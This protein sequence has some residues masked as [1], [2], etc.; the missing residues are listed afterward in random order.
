[1]VK[2]LILTT[3][4]VAP[5]LVLPWQ[6]KA[7]RLRMEAAP[8]AS[9]EDR[10]TQSST[11][12]EKDVEFHR[13]LAAILEAESL[14][15]FS[16][17]TLLSQQPNLNFRFSRSGATP[18]TASVQRWSPTVLKTLLDAGADPDFPDLEGLTPLAHI[19]LRECDETDEANT[20]ALLERSARAGGHID[21][22]RVY[23]ENPY[24]LPFEVWRDGT[25]RKVS[26]VESAF[27][28]NRRGACAE[29]LIRYGAAIDRHAYAL[30]KE[31]RADLKG[32]E[33]SRPVF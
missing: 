24:T 25:V 21:F 11:P 2:K 22:P 13:G 18:L 23:T 1:M 15:P 33:I 16:L 3:L 12:D 8:T 19:F 31:T 26:L 20:R 29:L 7:L 32:M 30:W 9:V 28:H 10:S 5:F 27:F 4:M 14:N 17:T 6:P